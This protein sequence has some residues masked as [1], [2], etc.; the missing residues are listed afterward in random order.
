M[1]TAAAES[2]AANA[3]TKSSRATVSYPYFDLE[4]SVNVAR[5]IHDKAGG[6][7]A[8]DALAAH[9]GYKTTKSGTFQVRVSSAKQFGLIRVESNGNFVPT[10]RAH[11]ILSPVMPEDSLDAKADAFLS[12]ELFRQIYERFV[13]NTLPPEVGVK[14]LLAQTFKISPDRIDPTARVFFDSADQAGFFKTGGDRTRL[15]R[16]A[17]KVGEAQDKTKAPE[18]QAPPV[19]KLK[20]PPQNPGTGGGSD[21]TGGVHTAIIG[22]LRE[23]PPAG[24]HWPKKKKDRF[25]KAFQATLDFIYPSDDEPEEGSP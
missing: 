12:V 23:L 5:A 19:D 6:A 10:E 15:I 3:A 16:P 1:N 7:C 18:H 9:L 22:L 20:T 14:N 25:V 17:S 21:G 13:N 4:S 2:T 11:K 8:A 24:A